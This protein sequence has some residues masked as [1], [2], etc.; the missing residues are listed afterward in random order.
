MSSTVKILQV[1]DK[2]EAI[3]V[4]ESLSKH[5]AMNPADPE[6]L[7]DVSNDKLHAYYDDDAKT[8]TLETPDSSTETF[9]KELLIDF[10]VL[11]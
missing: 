4:I 2:Q 6:N 11:F 9:I 8:V 10:P 7:L 1:A 3:Q 5:Y